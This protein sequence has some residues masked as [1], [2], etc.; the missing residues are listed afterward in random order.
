MTLPP[1]CL[2]GASGFIGRLLVD[3]LREAGVRDVTLLQRQPPP[4]SLPATWRSVLIDLTRDPIPDDAI[5]RGAVVLHLAAATGNAR[6]RE[7]QALNVAGTARLLEA[8]QQAG[9]RHFIFVS[10][11]AAGYADQRWAPY[12]QSK[13]AAERLVIAAGVPYTLVRPTMVFGAGSPNQRALER[14]ATLARPVLPGQGDVRVQP[15]HASDVA[16]ALLHLAAST[17]TSAVLTLGGPS[18]LSMRDLFAAIRRARGLA[19][20][21]PL[22]L[23]LEALRRALAFAGRVT[24]SAL[25][26]SAGRFVAFAN[27]STAAAAPERGI[28][29]PRVT[30]EQMLAPGHA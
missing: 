2:T 29:A 8:A 21:Q 4:R 28:P 18:T 10:S 30:L 22:T 13:A 16:D 20:R 12:A 19:P 15:I 1:I 14:L 25:P 26:V 6:P 27:D 24:G 7:M 5:A 9:T 11:V 17:P 23:P 3:R